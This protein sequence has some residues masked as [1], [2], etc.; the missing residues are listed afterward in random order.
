[1]NAIMFCLPTSLADSQFFHGDSWMCDDEK[2]KRQH[3]VLRKVK[4]FLSVREGS[5]SPTRRTYQRQSSESS[6]F[7]PSH[8]MHRVGNWQAM[9]SGGRHF[10]SNNLVRFKKNHEGLDH[11]AKRRGSTD[12]EII[13]ETSKN[14]DKETCYQSSVD[15]SISKMDSS[16]SENPVIETESK[17]S[18]LDVQPENTSR[19]VT[20]HDSGSQSETDSKGSTVT[21]GGTNTSPSGGRPAF[22]SEMALSSVESRQ[23]HSPTGKKEE[24]QPGTPATKASNDDT[25]DNTVGSLPCFPTQ[26]VISSTKTASLLAESG[27]ASGKSNVSTEHAPTSPLVAINK[28]DMCHLV[29]QLDTKE[30]DIVEFSNVKSKKI[31]DKLENTS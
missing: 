27:T 6:V 24:K 21:E 20:E 19:V 28:F 23:Q 22:P 11:Y 5:P 3:S 13:R 29:E 26:L 4:R 9:H 7:F 10:T 15:E 25:I 17:E 12:L 30:T 18:K 1:M 2:P 14:D 31:S 8:E 16:I